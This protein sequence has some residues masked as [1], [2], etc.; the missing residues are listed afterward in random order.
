MRK[1]AI[2]VLAVPILSVVY[3]STLL[4]RSLVARTGFAIGLGAIL[5]FG[6]ILTMRPA[7]TTATP[8]STILPVTVANFRTVVA[9]DRA[10][11]APVTIEF[12]APMDETSVAAALKVSP[13]TKVDLV[14]GRGGSPPDDHAGRSLGAGD[15]PHGDRRRGRAGRERRAD[16]VSRPGRLPDP[17]AGRR[18]DRRD[19]GGRQADRRR[20]R[21][22]DHL[23]R[24]G[25][26]VVGRAEHPRRAGRG[27]H[28]PDDVARRRP[29]ALHV[30]AAGAA[31]RQHHVPGRRRRRPGRRRRRGRAGDPSRSGPSP[32]PAVV[33]FRPR[34][35][36]SAVARDAA[37]SV[38]FTKTMDRATTKAAFKVTVGGKAVD[39]KIKLRRGRQGPRLRAGEGAPVRQKVVMEVGS[40]RA[41]RR[42]RRAGQGRPRATSRRS[43]RPTRSNDVV[44]R[45][46]AAAVAAA[47]RSAAAAGRR[48]RPTTCA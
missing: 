30:L 17:R 40:T 5:A 23:R 9:T 33:R 39:G 24:P 15:L 3:L 28:G 45:Q 37:I 27:R 2:A 11:D 6:V 12:S 42:G 31:P 25:R 29:D 19:P 21:V 41:E 38:R 48:S 22:R 34:D 4:G 47:A 36:T 20:D 35:D 32:R 18:P 10:L 16:V 14:V 13:A 43:P 1:L 26:P 7:P 8:P 46:H 44:Q